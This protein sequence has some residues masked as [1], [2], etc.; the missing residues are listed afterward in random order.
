[1]KTLT[2]SVV[3][4]ASLAAAVPGVG[5]AQTVER[6]IEADR[7]VCAVPTSPYLGFLEV[8]DQGNWTGMDIDICRAIGIAIL[9]PDAQIEFNALSWAD[10]FAALQSGAVDVVAMATGWTRSRDTQLGLQFS[11]PYYFGG[12]QLMVHSNLGVSSAAELDGATICAAA[13]TTVERSTASYLSSLGVDYEMLTFENTSDRNAAYESERCQALA[14][15]GP[16]N[17]VMRATSL[18]ADAHTL[19]PDVISNEPIS[20]VI[21]Q[22]DQR[23]M[24][25]VNWAISAMV[26][27]DTLGITSQ[28]AAEMRDDETAVPAVRTL[29]GATPGFGEGLGLEDDWAFNVITN[30]G[31][32]SEVFANNLGDNSPYGLP[33]GSNQAWT[34]GGILWAPVID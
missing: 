10:R 16:G 33:A 8:D 27:A 6:I 21:A 4:I 29:L 31:A 5:A 22:G 7:I 17:A 3:A 25:I 23:M 18:S 19:L 24:D 15:W 34:N 30:V 9:G 2:K 32:Y 1:M 14:G 20:A 26:A 12:A 11:L 28:N 13:G